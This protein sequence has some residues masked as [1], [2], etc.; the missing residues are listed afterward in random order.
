MTQATATAS[1]DRNRQLSSLSPRATLEHQSSVHPRVDESYESLVS[2]IKTNLDSTNQ[3]ALD[4]ILENSW[5]RELGFHD[6]QESRRIPATA[7]SPTYVGKASDIHFIHSVNRC[8]NG[9]DSSSDDV[10]AQNYSQTHV[11]QSPMALRDPLLPSKDEAD[12][13]MGVYLSTIHIAYP[14]LPKS[15]L[16]K[17]FERFKSGDTNQP[18]LRPLL[19]IFSLSP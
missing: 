17:A 16:L 15:P 19:A 12:L 13:F 7:P 9:R 4:L 8:V 11:S 5:L 6:L 10:G 14:F 3:N 1:P 18:E 2:S